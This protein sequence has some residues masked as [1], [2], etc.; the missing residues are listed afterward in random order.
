[1]ISTINKAIELSTEAGEA[2]LFLKSIKKHI[3]I[4]KIPKLLD[5]STYL[6]VFLIRNT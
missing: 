4:Y 5:L 1:M 3:F 2:K 6:D